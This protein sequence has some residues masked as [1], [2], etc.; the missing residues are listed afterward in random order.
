MQ[1]TIDRGADDRARNLVREALGILM[2]GISPGG[3]PR[4]RADM[5]IRRVA[6]V[7]WEEAEVAEL[8]V[9]LRATLLSVGDG[10]EPELPENQRKAFDLHP[11]IP[12]VHESPDETQ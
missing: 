1:F 8:P 2:R 5:A 11:D 9:D 6:H 7:L 10:T 12:H 4:F 3:H